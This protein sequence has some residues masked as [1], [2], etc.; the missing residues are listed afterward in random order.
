MYGPSGTGKT[1]LVK[2]IGFEMGVTLFYLECSNF[3][4]AD[5]WLEEADQIIEQ[6]MAKAKEHKPSVLMFD[7]FECLFKSSGGP[8]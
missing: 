7:D 5:S 1:T 6:M 2:A 8:K 4:F 3:W